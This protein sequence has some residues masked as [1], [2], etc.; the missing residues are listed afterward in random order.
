MASKVRSAQTHGNNSRVYVPILVDIFQ[1]KYQDGDEIVEFTLDEVR[2]T[3]ERL[4]IK[5]RNPSD[6][7]YRMKSRT[8]LPSEIL[9]KGFKIIKIVKKGVYQF[10]LGESTIVDLT[11]EN[12]FQIQ[13]TTPV[14][15]RR[16]LEEKLSE[17]DE[18]GL[19]TI[20]HYCDLL[21]HFTGLKIY[22]L[23]SHVRKSIVNIGQVEVD[24]VDIGIGLDSLETPII[25]P[26]EAKSASDP[27]NWTQIANQVNFS[28]QLFLNY[29]IRPI[30]IKVDYDSLLHIIEF[31]PE[32]EANKIKIKNSATYNL[33]LSEEQINAIR[34]NAQNLR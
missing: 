11:R 17:I 4:D 32:M 10:Q 16:F 8:K 1:R 22:R 29:V 13:D 23:K 7:I 20:I 5:I 33:I 14:A 30:G 9:D 31:T 34:S 18:Q 6:L 26:I 25:F 27:L 21:S 15:V 2:E 28:K 19:L 24:E 3:A 12:V